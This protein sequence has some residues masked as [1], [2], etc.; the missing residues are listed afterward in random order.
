MLAEAM[1]KGIKTISVEVDALFM[2]ENGCFL[3][4]L[5]GKSAVKDA[6]LG[7]FTSAK[8]L[9]GNNTKWQTFQ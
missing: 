7:L 4:V 8:V 2:V 9:S 3:L 6:I 1:K 5:Q